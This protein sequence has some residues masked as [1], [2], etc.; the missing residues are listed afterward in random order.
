MARKLRLIVA[1]GWY[2]VV[3]RGNRRD[4]IFRTETDRRRFLGRRG[5]RPLPASESGSW[6][7]WMGCGQHQEMRGEDVGPG[8][9][10]GRTGGPGGEPVPG[11]G[12]S[13]IFATTCWSEVLQAAGESEAARQALE[14]LCRAYWFPV[15]ALIRRR[16]YDPE[17][18]RDFTQ[19]FF[20]RFLARDGLARARRER[21]SFRGYLSRAVQHYLADERD[22]ARTQKRGGGA[23]AIPLDSEMLE[24][25]SLQAPAEWT[26][27]RVFD[28]QWALAVMGE[29]RR[30]L[31][32]EMSEAG[33]EAVLRV[34]N[35][36]GSVGA[37]SLE[38]QARGLGMPVNTL[39][40]HLRRARLRQA[41]IVR[42]LIAE[43]VESPIQVEAELRELLAAMED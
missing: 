38:E 41:Q 7:A 40:S 33:R 23:E 11:R 18:A 8:R 13:G 17:T 5:S 24:E 20:V 32:T 19:G 15:Y 3:N 12:H 31:E 2:H 9:E 4:D 14:S 25:R 28:R 21:G 26:P 16:G 29:S 27:D 37:S 22:R 43:T 10:G 1:G 35:D 6:T 30:R 34:L 36:L 39:K 42:E